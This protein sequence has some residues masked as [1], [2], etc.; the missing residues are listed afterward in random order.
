MDLLLNGQT[1]FYRDAE[2]IDALGAFLEQR[3]AEVRRPLR[4]WSAGCSTGDEPY[5]VALECDRRGLDVRVVGTD[6]NT[7]ALATARGARYS[8]YKLRRVDDAFIARG[9]DVEGDHFVVSKRV[10]AQVSFAQQNLLADPLPV[11][12]AERGGFDLV[13]CRNVLIYYAPETARGVVVRLLEATCEGG[14]LGLGASDGLFEGIR[15]SE[16]VRVGDRVF[17][18][19][20]KAGTRA[21]VT[22][23]SA[24]PPVVRTASQP[25]LAAAK[26]AVKALPTSTVRDAVVDDRAER[27]LVQ[28]AERL[29]DQGLVA[30]ARAQVERAVWANPERSQLAMTLGH[31]CLLERNLD[32]AVDAYTKAAALTPLA[33]EAQLYLGFVHRRRMRWEDARTTLRRALFLEPRAWL[34]AYLLFGCCLRLGEHDAARAEARRALLLL[35]DEG[36]LGGIALGA[37]LFLRQA[38]TADEC[39]RAL[40]AHGDP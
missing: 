35:D 13:L 10:R 20:V 36:S 16:H 37:P 6:I 34:A 23:S 8:K 3:A 25:T 15:G 21:E 30:S 27:A 1:Y 19:R 5:S 40:H 32:G 24:Q 28:D 22:S 29:V 9:F 14:L 26:A 17:F 31:L 33:A 12:H 11:L 18:R 38:P 39:R 7:V 2:Q 4:V